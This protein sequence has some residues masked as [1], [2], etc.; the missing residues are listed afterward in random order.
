MAYHSLGKPNESEAALKQLI[1]DGQNEWACQIAQVY[2][3]RDDPD[4]A[5]AWLDRAYRQ[6]D[7]GLTFMEVD[8]ILKR[9]RPDQRYAELLKRLRLPT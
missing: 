2:A 1:A 8:L 5:F 3:Y 7:S 9:L 4:R 6:H